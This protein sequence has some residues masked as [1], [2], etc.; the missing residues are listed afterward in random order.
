MISTEKKFLIFKSCITLENFT[1][2]SVETVKQNF[3]ARIFMLNLTSMLAF[4]V[5]DLINTNHKDCKYS[6]QISLTQALA[7]MKNVGILLFIRETIAPIIA[8]LKKLF[9]WSVVPISPGR[10]FPR[11]SQFNQMRFAYAYKS[12]F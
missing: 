5:H 10:K 3:Y 8:K 11:K 6:Y 2:K 9:L 4:P 12:I 1:E 7:K